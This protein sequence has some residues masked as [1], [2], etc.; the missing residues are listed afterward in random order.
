MICPNCKKEILLIM[1]Y[2]SIEL[3]FCPECLG[4]WLDAEELQWILGADFDEQSIFTKSSIDETKKKCPRCRSYM[5]KIAL[6]QNE[7]II[8]DTC[9][10]NHGFWF[11]RGELERLVSDLP[12]FP[13]THS[14]L[15]WLTDVFS[16][17]PKN[18]Q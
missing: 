9:P 10:Y 2:D 7:K 4:V 3:D 5:H 14:F 15:Q 6:P 17:H 11:D 13:G 18:E 1:E 12:E 8:Y 16:Y